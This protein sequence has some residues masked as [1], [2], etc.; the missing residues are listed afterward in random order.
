MLETIMEQY[1]L[2]EINYETIIQLSAE[3]MSALQKALDT[4]NRKINRRNTFLYIISGAAIAET[5]ALVTL[6]AIK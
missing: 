2:D 1:K 4:A 5:I 3:D 6:I